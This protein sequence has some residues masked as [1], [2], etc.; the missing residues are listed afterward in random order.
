MTR[1]GAFPWSSSSSFSCFL[2]LIFSTLPSH[3]EDRASVTFDLSPILFGPLVKESKSHDTKDNKLLGCIECGEYRCPENPSKCL[4]GSV[5]DPCGCCK[6]GICA[7]LGGESC[8]NSSIT[9]PYVNTRKDG[10]CA[11][12]YFCQLRTDLQE[13]DVAETICI[14][15]EQT[16]ACGSDEVTYE[17]PC[18]LHEEA[19]RLK[20]HLSLKLQHLGPCQTRP[21]IVSNTEHVISNIGQ[22]VLLACE[23][24]GFPI[25]DIFWEYHSP[26]GKKVYKLTSEEY[27]ITVQSDQDPKSL[28]RT[29]WLQLPRFTK[30][31]VGTYHCIANNSMGE[32][33]AAS[34]VS[35]V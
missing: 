6:S 15:M 9:E 28:T 24:K 25:P 8:W 29:S 21:W 31:H 10:L 32:A 11:R 34:F 4:L 35:I 5:S 1:N 14:C 30:D 22:R 12:N 16:P 18:S 19:M 17:T 20:S 27:T 13:E 26:D 3:Q 2:F 33:G 7:R 23:T